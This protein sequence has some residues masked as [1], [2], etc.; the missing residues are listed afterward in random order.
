MQTGNQFKKALIVAAVLVAAVAGVVF[1]R[2]GSRRREQV[3]IERHFEVMGTSAMV[4]V[5]EFPGR[6]EE[7]RRAAEAAENAIFEVEKV[8]SRFDPESELFQLNATAEKTPFPCSEMLWEVLSRAR[9]GREES[10]GLFDVSSAPLM[11]LWGFY[12]REKKLPSPE[13][14]AEALR[15]TGLAK[16]R[17][18]D[19]GR[20]VFF[21]V[22]GMALDLGG[23]AKGYAVDLAAER[24]SRFPIGG[25]LINLGGNL[26]CLGELPGDKGFRIGVRGIASPDA[27]AGERRIRRGS[28][29]TSGDYER[30]VE[31]DGRRY[32]HIMDPLTGEPAPGGRAVTVF[33]PRAADADVFSTSVFLGGAELAEKLVAQ[34]PDTEIWIYNDTEKKVY[35]RKGG[36]L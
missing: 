10:G 3:L 12:R 26:R 4:L 9:K 29:A 24:M 30:F 6:P 2:P 14:K 1:F 11:T 17:F 35:K 18:D 16:V 36:V 27:I 28:A 22:P 20:T 33:T 19:A 31:I 7:A 8:C 25:A 13:E 34:Y 15:R 5:H 21:T 32:G 23:I